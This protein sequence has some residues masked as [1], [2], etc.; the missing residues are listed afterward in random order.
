MPDDR[1]AGDH[2]EHLV[3]P[4]AG[5]PALGAPAGG[6]AQP[7]GQGGVTRF[8]L[9]EHHLPFL[10]AFT[11]LAAYG[12]SLRGGFLN[13]DDDWLIR[14]NPI[15]QPAHPHPLRT[16]WTDLS[17]DT[18]HTLG[19]E[20]LPV[21]DTF[22]WLETRAFG[23]SAP[24]LRTLSLLLFIAAALLMRA[25]LRRTIPE[26]GT[27]ELAAWLFAL[28][29]LHAESVAWLAGQKDLVALVLVAAALLLHAR[30]R[31]PAAV[32]VLLLAAMF[33]KSVAVASPLLLPLH[34]LF[35]RRR[36]RWPVIAASMAAAV[37]ALAI[38]VQ[39]GRAV[40]ML[41]DWPGGSRLTALTTMGPV[42][43]RYLRLSFLPFD[44]SVHHD[45]SAHA[46][47]HVASWAAYLLL[48]ALAALAIREARRGRSLAVFALGWFLLPLLP[49]SQVIAPLQ[50][51]MADRYLLLAVL[52]PCLVVAALARHGPR[53]LA[54]GL[55]LIAA[56]LTFSRA[57]VFADSV[58]L[59]ED[60]TAKSPQWSQGWYQLGMA[61]PAAEA[62]PAFRRAIALEPGGEGARRARNNLAARLAGQERLVEAQAMLRD[63]VARFPDDPRALNNLAEI[64]ARL[65]D[66]GESRRLFERLRQRFPDY[67]RGLRNYRKRFGSESGK[68]N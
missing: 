56:A 7:A 63:N 48:L 44:L 14:D 30:D 11:L 35:T 51:L 2:E 43:L 1:R 42:W 66:E 18:R 31:F 19:A 54:A 33:G 17:A 68:S 24:A 23:F 39:V 52:G 53:P 8:R 36:P 3:P 22:V 4:E 27:A 41:A 26:P 46:A 65:G 59:W 61:L 40:G 62:E 6:G 49:T 60:A 55:V 5:E 45:V 57:Q 38:H 20:Y 50:N 16:I 58:S 12:L 21:R 25:Y 32:P 15:L 29:P 10:L 28:H 13:Y 64:T 67:Q 47:T 37:L 34:D 9:R